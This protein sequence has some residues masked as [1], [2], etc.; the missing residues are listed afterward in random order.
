[1][2]LER[3]GADDLAPMIWRR[4]FDAKVLAPIFWRQDVSGRKILAPTFWHRSVL[5][6]IRFDAAT[7]WRG[8]VLAPYNS[9]HGYGPYFVAIIVKSLLT[10]YAFSIFIVTL[11]IVFLVG[12]FK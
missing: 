9:F 12:I 7:F 1:M 11:M 6:P 4:C 2:G 3:S 5:A 8:D 10:L